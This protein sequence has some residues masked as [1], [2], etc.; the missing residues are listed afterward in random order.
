MN[1][2]SDTMVQENVDKL[3]CYQSKANQSLDFKRY[4]ISK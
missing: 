2:R 3:K 1:E 4:S